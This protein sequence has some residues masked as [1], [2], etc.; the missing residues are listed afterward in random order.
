MEENWGEER[1]S[2]SELMILQGHSPLE[3][4]AQAAN[5]WEDFTMKTRFS[6][7]VDVNIHRR[8]KT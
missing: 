3:N 4:E 5:R 7:E 6:Q 8:R 1:E 2:E